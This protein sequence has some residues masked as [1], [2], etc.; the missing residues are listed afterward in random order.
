MEKRAVVLTDGTNADVVVAEDQL[1]AAVQV[2]RV[3]HRPPP[4][5]RLGE[6]AGQDVEVQPAVAFSGAWTTRHRL[7]SAR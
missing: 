6:D 7:A 5:D 1:E 4:V 2:F 3:R